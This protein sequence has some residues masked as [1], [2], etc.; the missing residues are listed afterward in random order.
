[1]LA[2]YADQTPHPKAAAATT[3]ARVLACPPFCCARWIKRVALKPASAASTAATSRS[4]Q[5]Y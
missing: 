2:K 3:T 4:L 1:M 5:S